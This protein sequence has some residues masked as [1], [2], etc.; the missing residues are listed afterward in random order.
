MTL[1]EAQQQTK[2]DST[3]TMSVASIEQIEVKVNGA[4]LSEDAV[5][6]YLSWLD[7]YVHTEGEV[8]TI[9]DDNFMTLRSRVL[10]VAQEAI[11]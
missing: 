6:A 2:R 10:S 9:S 8:A 7:K 1:E 11:W 3:I 4:T 5:D